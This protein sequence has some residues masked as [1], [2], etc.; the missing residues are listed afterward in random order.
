MQ[1]LVTTLND[2]GVCPFLHDVDICGPARQEMVDMDGLL[3][4]EPAAS[5]NGLCHAGLEVVLSRRQERRKEE[6]MVGELQIP[7]SQKLIV[8]PV[9]PLHKEGE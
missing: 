4:S 3:L 8:D 5:A 9:K 7:I 6:D 2:D 1:N